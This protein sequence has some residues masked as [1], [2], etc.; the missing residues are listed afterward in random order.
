MRAEDVTHT[1]VKVFIPGVIRT[2][3]AYIHR[4]I[5]SM[6]PWRQY[7]GSLRRLYEMEEVALAQRTES[8]RPPRQYMDPVPEWWMDNFS[9][10]PRRRD[11]PAPDPSNQLRPSAQRSGLRGSRGR[12]VRRR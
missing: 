12:L 9:L 1:A 7:A 11:S 10:V 3:R 6:R 2:E 5:A 8:R 4:V